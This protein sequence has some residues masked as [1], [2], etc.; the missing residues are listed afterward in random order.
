VGSGQL[1]GDAHPWSGTHSGGPPLLPL[2][3]GPLLL[4]LDP[5]PLLL[6]DP[7][8]LLLPEYPLLEPPLVEPLLLPVP[9]S[10]PG[11]PPI[12]PPQ[13]TERNAGSDTERRRRATRP[14]RFVTRASIPRR[15]VTRSRRAGPFRRRLLRGAARLERS[16]ALFPPCVAA[17]LR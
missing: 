8:P 13:W 11:S 3:T 4:P 12:L 2:D 17:D 1:V 5:G 16:G 6:L 7:G 10:A 14:R 15:P 9:P